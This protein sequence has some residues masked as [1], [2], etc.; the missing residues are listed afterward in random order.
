MRRQIGR[1]IGYTRVST[2]CQC[3]DLQFDAV[4]M[5]SIVDDRLY[6]DT[7]S[8]KGA[9]RKALHEGYASVV[10]R[11][12]RMGRSLLDLVR[13]VAELERN[14]IGF[15]SLAERIETGSAAGNLVS[16]VFA[17]LAVFEPNLIRER[18][19]AGLV[20]VRAREYGDRRPKLDA[21]QMKAT[22]QLMS[23]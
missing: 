7:A 6:S 5:A 21:Q 16:Y 1:R 12:D 19:R 14:G 22:R 10:W 17:A 15:E 23:D 11:L 9:E 8:G 2:D 4:H 3:L 20:A 18:A 13:I